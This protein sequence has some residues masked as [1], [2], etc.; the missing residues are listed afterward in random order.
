M[1]FDFCPPNSCPAPILFPAEV[2]TDSVVLHW[3]ATADRYLV[4]YRLTGQSHWI[5]DNIPTTDTF[6]TIDRTL[7]F[8]SNY[9]YHV[10]QYCDSGRVSNWSFGTFNT[11]DIPCRP[12]AHLRVTDVTNHSARLM[13]SPEGNHIGYYV[14]IWNTAF[15]TVITTYIVGCRV[16]GLNPAT[17]FYASVEVVC[18]YI[19]APSQWSD[20]VSFATDA[21][22]DATDLMALEVGGNSVL[23]DWQCE[24]GVDEWLIEWGLQG[25]DQG[26]GVTVTADHHPFLLTGLTGETTYD[27]VVRAVCGDDYYSEAWSPR[28]TITTAYSGIETDTLTHSPIHTFSIYPNPTTG[29][30]MLTIL[31]SEFSILNSLRVEVIDMTGRRCL[32]VSTSEH[33]NLLVTGASNTNTMT[34]H[35]NTSNTNTITHSHNNAFT[36][37]L[38][39]SQLP[40]GAYYVRLTGDHFSAVKKLVKTQ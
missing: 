32:N 5:E 15:D 36:I 40:A 4:G 16:S 10:R 3:N 25:F 28:L 14:H 20:T 12:P 18:E 24:E 2:Y 21:C 31:N 19:N 6:Y 38:P 39:V 7:Y 23:L 1:S 17:R 26:T 8:D 22:P 33:A 29:D 9:L 34:S 13:W 37:A 35:N 11:A 30:V 27:I